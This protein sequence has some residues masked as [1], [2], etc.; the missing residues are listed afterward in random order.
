[1]E[2]IEDTVITVRACFKPS[3]WNTHTKVLD[4]FASVAGGCP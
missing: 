2:K 3:I 4:P 1:M